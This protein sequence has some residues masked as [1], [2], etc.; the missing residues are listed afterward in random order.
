MEKL[1]RMAM[2][3]DMMNTPDGVEDFLIRVVRLKIEDLEGE[4][5]GRNK[6]IETLRTQVKCGDKGEGTKHSLDVAEEMVRQRIKAKKAFRSTLV[7]LQKHESL[8]FM[9]DKNKK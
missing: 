4:I 7:A 2:P 8:S 5:I 3:L 6:Q 9:L 1:V